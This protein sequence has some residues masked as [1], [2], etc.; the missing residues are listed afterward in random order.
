MSNIFFDTR[1]WSCK[2][3]LTDEKYRGHPRPHFPDKGVR[4]TSVPVNH[5]WQEQEQFSDFARQ[6]GWRSFR[7]ATAE[8]LI[9]TCFLSRFHCQPHLF[10]LRLRRDQQHISFDTI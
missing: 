7:P 5:T 1:G 8:S 3:C 10:P 4:V 2:I 6:G 9:G